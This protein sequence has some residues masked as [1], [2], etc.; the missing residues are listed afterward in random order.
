VSGSIQ[1][2]ELNAHSFGE[3]SGFENARVA[4]TKSELER[5]SKQNA[6]QIPK[7]T[8]GLGKFREK[9]QDISRC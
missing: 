2:R 9:K 7:L 1:E 3:L 8:K 6:K 5:L 4:L